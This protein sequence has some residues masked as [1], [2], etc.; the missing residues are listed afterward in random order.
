MAEEWIVD[1]PRVLD[2]GGENERVEKVI[3]GIIG[4]HVDVVTHDDSPTAR[5]E[6]SRVEGLPLRVS[7]DGRTLKILHGKDMEAGLLDTLRRLVET[8]GSQRA[9]VSIS[10]P[11]QAKASLS[12]VS[13]PIVASGLRRGVTANTVSGELTISDIHGDTSLNTVSGA[14]EC[15]DLVGDVKINSV[16]GAVTVQS[17]E[18]P[19]ASINTVS[20]EVALD[21]RN[22][23]MAVKSNSVSGDVT[24]RA[25]FTGYSVAAASATGHV[26]VD[27]QSLSAS[28]TGSGGPGSRRGESGGPGASLRSGDE[29]LQLKAHSVSGN[30]V[31][32]RS[33]ARS[34]DPGSLGSPEARPSSPQ[35]AGPTPSPQDAPGPAW[36][37]GDSAGDQPQDQP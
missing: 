5:V 22:S 34:G 12:T 11:A 29:S 30:V 20:G 18:I 4:G 26:V 17:S 19:K 3:V 6:V 35:D 36:P 1:G 28:F 25:P 16:S 31:L 9:H 15:A 24:I 21:V 7:W 32:L 33:G 14:T 27:G 2:I 23:R 10:V 13:A 8:V 37:A